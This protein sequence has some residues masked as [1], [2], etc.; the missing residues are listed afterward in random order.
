MNRERNPWL[1]GVIALVA[2]LLILFGGQTV[3]HTFA[4]AKP[5][6]KAFDGIDGVKSVAW[7]N[8]EGKAVSLQVS[9]DNAVNLQETYK[10]IESKAKSVLGQTPLKINI[11]DTRNAE[12]EKVL[13][14]MHFDIQEAIATGRFS[15]MAETIK[16]KA[17]N[18][19][20]Q[21]QVYIDAQ[22]VYLQLT[23]GEAD[24][25][26]VIPRSTSDSGVR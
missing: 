5:L 15:A 4:V 13:H 2:T 21:E 18:Y 3:Y 24:L 1:S 12:L 8:I 10:K 11:S 22:N 23:K 14:E 25:Y 26:A 9:L 6:D 16:N 20:V 19:G 17:A 7:E